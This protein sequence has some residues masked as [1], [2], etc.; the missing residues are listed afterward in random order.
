MASA[1]TASSVG[2]TSSVEAGD[3]PSSAAALPNAADE[4]VSGAAEHRGREMTMM[5]AVSGRADR[6]TS[7]QPANLCSPGIID[8]SGE[9]C[10]EASSAPMLGRLYPLSADLFVSPGGEVGVGTTSPAYL[11]D[12]AGPG[13]FAG[14]LRIQAP[15]GFNSGNLFLLHTDGAVR[16]KLWSNDGNGSRL[17]LH[18]HLENMTARLN[19]DSSTGEGGILELRPGDGL[20]DNVRLVASDG[21]GAR[22]SMRPD[23]IGF[24][25]V[26]LQARSGSTGGRMV[27]RTDTQVETIEID[28]E[29]GDGNGGEINVRNASGS[30]TI[31]LNGQSGT[32][33]TQTLQITG[34]SDVAESF[35][36]AGASEVIPGTVLAIDSAHPG[37]LR[38]CNEPYDL[39]VAGVVSGA[40]GVEPGLTLRQEGSV[41]DGRHPVALSGRVY[42]RCTTESGPIEPGDLLTSSSSAGLAMKAV[43]FER[44][45]GAVLGKAMSHLDAGNGLVLV[46]VSLQ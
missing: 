43:D 16:V 11:L 14:G 31:V 26:V 1:V 38:V 20:Q 2:L 39:A 29:Q 7:A 42:V 34:G 3:L 22:L 15:S 28:A 35:E 37:S 5:D 25:T 9:A 24:G 18:N 44:R 23:G 41:A 30:D 32:T 4:D 12:V 19:A 36:I 40:A 45:K 17:E 21:A 27:L 13:R 8:R 46:L 6:A 33:T 10:L